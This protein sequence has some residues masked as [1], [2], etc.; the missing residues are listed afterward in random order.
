ML[1]YQMLI[2]A[3]MIKGWVGGNVQKIHRVDELLQLPKN[4][5]TFFQYIADSFSDQW[6]IYFLPLLLLMALLPLVVGMRYAWQQRKVQPAWVIGGLLLTG[7]ILPAIGLLGVMGPMLALVKPLLAARVMIGVGAWLSMGLVVAY[8]V[9][10]QWRRSSS[11][12]IAAAGM[13]ALGMQ[14]IASAYGNALSEQ[15]RYEARI[16]TR[17][18]DDYAAMEATAGVRALLLDGSAGYAPATMH[19]IEQ[20]PI[21]GS[22]INP[23]LSAADSFRTAGFLA[24]HLPFV[25]YVHYP[26]ATEDQARLLAIKAKIAKACSLPAWRHARAYD[27]Y[28]VDDI[29]VA[30]FRN[31]PATRCDGAADVASVGIDDTLLEGIPL[32]ASD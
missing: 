30:V 32:K 18:A 27:L 14:V 15:A 26:E 22:M 16:A 19:A 1:V 28:K 10:E 11:W 13:L 20:M 23:Y 21:L 3:T 9:L 2:G 17:L 7:L 4:V 24:F 25:P 31:R 12:M 29:A 8:A 6:R 5:M